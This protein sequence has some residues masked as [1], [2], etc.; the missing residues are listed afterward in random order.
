LAVFEL[1]LLA[2]AMKNILTI[3]QILL[4]RNL[5]PRYGWLTRSVIWALSHENFFL[6]V[7]AVLCALS[8]F[9]LLV[10]IKRT[11]KT[12]GNPAQ[13][14]RARFLARAQTRF[15]ASVAIGAVFSILIATVGVTYASKKMELSPPLEIPATGD[16]ILIPLETV[17]DGA[18]HRFVHKVVNGP[19]VTNVR[20]IVI[21]KNDAAYGVGLDACDVCGPS[22]YY[23]RG[24][25]VV[26]ILCD[27]VMNTATI[28][29]PGGCNPVP[30]KFEIAGGN[31]VIKTSSLAAEARRFY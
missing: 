8:A 17:N 1:S 14:R 3:G 29:L 27:V 9:F 2:L 23:Q 6:Y 25:Q 20:Y 28:G 16:E 12:G 22:G 13:A 24:K 7:M 31:M 26:C 10:D 30:L 4:G 15:C 19:S 11:P 21:R 18:L 5:I